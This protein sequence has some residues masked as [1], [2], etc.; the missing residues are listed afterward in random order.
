[1]SY[2]LNNKNK[3]SPFGRA[4]IA[5]LIAEW[6]NNAVHHDFKGEEVPMGNEAHVVLPIEGGQN[7]VSL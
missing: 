6:A 3:L 4:V 1:M 5:V 7:A 2:Q